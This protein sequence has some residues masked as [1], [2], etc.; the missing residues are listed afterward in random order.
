MHIILN[1]NIKNIFILEKIEFGHFRVQ[2][3]INAFKTKCM[4]FNN[5]RSQ[6][7][8]IVEFMGMAN[9]LRTVQNY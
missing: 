8:D 9:D 7:H 3:G 2:L 5:S 6:A 4:Y 1:L